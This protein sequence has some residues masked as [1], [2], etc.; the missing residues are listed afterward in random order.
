MSLLSSIRSLVR[1]EEDLATTALAHVLRTSPVVAEE[2]NNILGVPSASTWSTQ[3]H[4]DDGE[5]SRGRPDL[6]ALFEGETRALVEAKFLAGLTAAQPSHYLKML[7]SDGVLMFLVPAGRLAYLER[8][9]LRRARDMPGVDVEEVHD[10][11]QGRCAT[12]AFGDGKR[13][14]LSFLTWDVLLSNLLTA[15]EHSDSKEAL[16]DLRQIISLTRAI[17]GEAFIPFTS[18]QLTSGEIPRVN[19]Q[20]RSLLSALRGELIASGY[21]SN[22]NLSTT[23]SGWAGMSLEFAG[24]RWSLFESWE[25]WQKFGHSPIW[26]TLD[27]AD[28]LDHLRLLEVWFDDEE[29]GAV[30]IDHWKTATIAAPLLI[31]PVAD[32]EEVLESMVV[33]V[34]N[35]VQRVCVRRGDLPDSSQK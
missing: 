23:S 34:N 21:R 3:V 20:I 11:S 18:E 6:V 10:A 28:R 35:L 7:A 13:C 1:S 22:G 8:E 29:L 26:F 24:F 4:L 14:A 32:R 5:G 25:S 12:V 30:A 27:A 2:F 15:A 31:P 33:R 17:E 16:A 19:L 9:V